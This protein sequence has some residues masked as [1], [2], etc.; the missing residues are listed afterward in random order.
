[1]S[2]LEAYLCE[3]FTQKAEHPDIV[4]VGHLTSRHE[5]D[6]NSLC[7]DHIPGVIEG[8]PKAAGYLDWRQWRARCSSLVIFA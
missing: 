8:M 3:V 4:P 6:L 5:V 7:E 2:L 1:M